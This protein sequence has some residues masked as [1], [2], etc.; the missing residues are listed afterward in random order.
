[1]R[2]CPAPANTSVARHMT[3]NAGLRLVAGSFVVLS[4]ALAHFVNPWF[5]AFTVFVGLNQIQSAFSGWC[6]MVWLLGRLGF[7][8]EVPVSVLPESALKGDE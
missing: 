1:M 8:R 7:E 2:C 3:I 4:V 5:L 6:P